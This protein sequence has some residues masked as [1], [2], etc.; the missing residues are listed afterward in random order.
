[1]KYEFIEVDN[2]TTKIK[3]KE[4]EYEIKRNVNLMLKF[5]SLNVKARMQMI[6][7]LAKDGL[8]TKDLVVER[9]EKGKT[10]YDNSNLKEM[11][12]TYI[13]EASMQL[14]NELS[15]EYFNMSLVELLSN[16]DLDEKETTE[17]TNR[18]LKALTGVKIETPSK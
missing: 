18:F 13:N 16:L 6:K 1:M 7:D 4:K 12:D 17:F 11:E 2:D 3:I 14:F 15:I 10:Y 8:T 5:Q 9:K